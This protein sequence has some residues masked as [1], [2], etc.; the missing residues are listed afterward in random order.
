MHAIS[1]L[2]ELSRPFVTHTPHTATL[3]RLTIIL[4]PT[5]V[6][7]ALAVPAAKRK[8]GNPLRGWLLGLFA[9]LSM[10]I[11]RLPFIT[12]RAFGAG[13]AAVFGQQPSITAELGF[14]WNADLLA[15][16]L[17][18]VAAV[19][20]YFVDPHPGRRRTVT[21]SLLFGAMALDVLYGR[22][23]QAWLDAAETAQ[24]AEN[25]LGLHVDLLSVLFVL[26]NAAA[27]ALPLCSA[28]RSRKAAKKAVAAG[29]RTS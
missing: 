3:L 20:A 23:L 7:L 19:Y 6:L 10:L 13:I 21:V 29:R 25:A 16:G 9:G 28:F 18:W 4:V 24:Y 27:L 12:I 2:F 26:L 14:P 11:I 15:L 17:F 1:E 22:Y 5:A 8:S